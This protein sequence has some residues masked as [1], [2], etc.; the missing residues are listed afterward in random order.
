VPDTLQALVHALIFVAILFRSG[1]YELP[2]SALEGAPIV[3]N[4][5][6]SLTLALSHGEMWEREQKVPQ[7]PAVNQLRTSD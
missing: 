5:P 3:P 2:D 1:S 7:P 4:V 6:V